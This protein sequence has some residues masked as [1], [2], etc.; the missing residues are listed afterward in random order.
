M[1][2][3]PIISQIPI[4]SIFNDIFS[5]DSNNSSKPIINIEPY[6]TSNPI[7]FSPKPDPNAP[8]Q[9]IVANTNQLKNYDQDTLIYVVGGVIIFI[10]LLKK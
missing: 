3:V 9:A 2:N 10:I 6:P 7:I 5:S 8:R 1:G 4:V